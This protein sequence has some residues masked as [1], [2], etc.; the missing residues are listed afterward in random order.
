L[1]VRAG[2]RLREQHESVGQS[3]GRGGVAHLG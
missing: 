3:V 1:L 2:Q